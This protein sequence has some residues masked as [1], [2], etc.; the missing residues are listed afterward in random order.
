MRRCRIAIVLIVRIRVGGR[1][2][3]VDNKSLMSCIVMVVVILSNNDMVPSPFAG[4]HDAN[5]DADDD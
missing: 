2:L 4:T 5:D 1:V 3:M